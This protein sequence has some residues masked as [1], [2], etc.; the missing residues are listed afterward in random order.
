MLAKPFEPERLSEWPYALVQPKLNG[1]RATYNNGRL[2]SSH[3]IEI[4]SA[5]HI[6]EALLPLP[7]SIMLDGELYIHGLPLQTIN[8]IASR[9]ANNLHESYTSLEYHVFDAVNLEE[10][11]AKQVDRL[12]L[13]KALPTSNNDS[14][15]KVE[16][17][18]VGSKESE[19]TTALLTRYLSEGFE[20]IIFRNPYAMYERKRSS[21]LLKLKPTSK[22]TYKIVGF[23]EERSIHGKPKG[24][25]G[26][27]LVTSSEGITF[28]VGSGLTKDQRRKLWEERCMLPGRSVV[29][30]YQ[31]LTNG[32]V[33]MHPVLLEVKNDT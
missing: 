27:L 26:S 2:V 14:I 33:P 7:T 17:R 28:S 3:G 13:L 12:G 24:T 32:S 30:K 8:S 20:G 23:Q 31:Y 4:E 1:K 11:G 5:P 10:L 29:V 22:D 16:T 25:L 9:K 6:L 19:K 15:K 18:V 21:N